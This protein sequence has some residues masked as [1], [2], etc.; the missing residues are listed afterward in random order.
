MGFL[1]RLASYGERTALVFPGRPTISYAEL[2]RR[3]AAMAAEFGAARKLVALEASNSEHAIIAYLA[4]R[5]GG[6]VV[7]LIAPGDAQAFDAF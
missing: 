5:A 4:A 3:V 2:A 1:Q 6:H 7:A